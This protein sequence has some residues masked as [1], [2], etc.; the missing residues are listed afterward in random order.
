MS[1]EDYV[2]VEVWIRKDDP[3]LEFLEE[4][5]E[6]G[7]KLGRVVKRLLKRLMVIYRFSI[8]DRQLES[9]LARAYRRARRLGFAIS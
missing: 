3:L 9:A 4:Y 8:E 1:R 2:V 5:R 7:E 6:G